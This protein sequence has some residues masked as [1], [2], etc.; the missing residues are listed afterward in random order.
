MKRGSKSELRGSQS[1][2]DPPAEQIKSDDLLT[3]LKQDLDRTVDKYNMMLY[4]MRST[5]TKFNNN[6]GTWKPNGV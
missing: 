2:S 6:M 1:W 4:L 3:Q 5:M